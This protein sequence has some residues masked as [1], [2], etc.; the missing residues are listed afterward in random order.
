MEIFSLKNIVLPSTLNK[1][2]KF[3]FKNCYSL[4][5]IMI[6]QSITKIGKSAFSGCSSL[7]K[8]IIFFNFMK[9]RNLITIDKFWASAVNHIHFITIFIIKCDCN[10]LFT[11]R[12]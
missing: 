4:I 5:V 2:S 11:F 12:T 10:F 3:T 8:G 9:I 7:E 1:I 6:P